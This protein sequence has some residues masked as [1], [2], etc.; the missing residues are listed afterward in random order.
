MKKVFIIDLVA[1]TAFGV[2]A[3][4]RKRWGFLMGSLGYWV[5]CITRFG[6]TRSLEAYVIANNLFRIAPDLTFFFSRKTKQR[7]WIL[8]VN[9]QYVFNFSKDGQGFSVYPLAESVCRT[10]FYGKQ[11]VEV[12][13]VTTRWIEVTR[14]SLLFF[15]LEAVLHYPLSERSFFKCGSEI[16][17]CRGWQCRYHV[18][19]WL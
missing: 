2:N 5:T 17:V 3:Q 13:G 4:T 6:F 8:N 19:L 9:F 14:P 12:N 1:M 11:D 7:D 10:T 18:R 16:Y 15:N